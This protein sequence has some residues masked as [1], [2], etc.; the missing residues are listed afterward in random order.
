M[1]IIFAKMLLMQKN[2]SGW[3]RLR[4]L[5]SVLRGGEAGWEKR[6]GPVAMRL[7]LKIAEASLHETRLGSTPHPDH[8][9]P[10]AVPSEFCTFQV[11][12]RLQKGIEEQDVHEL[13]RRMGPWGSTAGAQPQLPVLPLAREATLPFAT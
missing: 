11:A 6:D 5:E 3:L 7:E 1:V 13:I 2:Q 4:G 10:S 8:T 12:S 9:R